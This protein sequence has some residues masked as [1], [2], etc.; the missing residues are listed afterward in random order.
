MISKIIRMVGQWTDILSTIIPI[1]LDMVYHSN[2]SNHVRVDNEIQDV[3]TSQ[4]GRTPWVFIFQQFGGL[5]FV[6]RSK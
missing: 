1:L 5:S 4:T 6:Q 2:V 3:Q